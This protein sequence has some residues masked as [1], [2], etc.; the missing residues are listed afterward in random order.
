MW[1][2]RHHQ[3][4]FTQKIALSATI[5][6][7]LLMCL[8]LVWNA[9]LN[10]QKLTLWKHSLLYIESAEIYAFKKCLISNNYIHSLEWYIRMVTKDVLTNQTLSLSRNYFL[11]WIR[12]L[13][14]RCKPCRIPKYSKEIKLMCKRWLIL[15]KWANLTRHASKNI[16]F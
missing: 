13:L 7:S 16:N 3:Q 4:K 9:L 15:H 6:R 5:L 12:N 2:C 10:V 11:F 14:M 8:W 1:I